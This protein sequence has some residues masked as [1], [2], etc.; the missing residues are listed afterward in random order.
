METKYTSINIKKRLFAFILAIT[1]FVFL[2]ICRL[3][4]LQV[5]NGSG[6]NSRALTQWLRDIKVNSIRGSFI[7]RNG[8]V[9]ASSKTVYDVYVRPREV[10]NSEALAAT[11]CNI[12]NDDFNKV[13]EK[14]NKK[15][16]SEVKLA[17][18]VE[19]SDAQK[20]I[21][22]KFS[23]VY[24]SE[25]SVRNYNYDSLLCQLLGFVNSDGD[26]QAG[27]EM[28]YNK[29]LKGVSGASLVES[30]NAGR[31]LSTSEQYYLEPINGLNLTLTIDIL[32]QQE[33]EKIMQRAM[34]ET[35]SARATAIVMD[36][37]NSEVLSI[38]T[39]PSYNLNDI[40]RD[41]VASLMQLSKQAAITD[42]YEPGSTFKILTTA[43]ALE[44]KL[45]SEN[46]Y[47]YCSGF[48]IVN[49]VK[50][51]CHRKTGH[52]SQSL[53]KGLSNSCNCVF[54]ELISRIGLEKFY[55]YLKKFGLIDGYGMDFPGEGKAIT[56]PKNLVID[57]DLY[58]MGFGQSVAITPMQLA[59]S[60]CAIINGGTLFRPHFVTNYSN[61]NGTVFSET[62]HEIR[63]VV[64]QNTSEAINRM[65]EKVVDGGGGKRAY[66]DG[67]RIAG[68][69][70]TAQK[71][72][73]NAIAKGKY[74]ASFIGYMPADNP[75]YL[76]LVVLDEP[77]GSFYGGVVAAPV[78]REIFE[79]IIRLRE[80]E[81]YSNISNSNVQDI[82]V[83]NLIGKTMTEAVYILSNLGLD[84]LVDDRGSETVTSQYLS[85]GS[86]C[87]KGDTILLV[88]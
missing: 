62:N 12:T 46:D 5:I 59:N 52:G 67:Y 4:Y 74:I 3:F 48:R 85:P 55:S 80:L 60:V 82:V 77:K 75:E 73:N 84:Y 71:Y 14:V 68:K 39:L 32:L 87:A 7:D 18:N 45:T 51:N 61:N 30:D 78:A 69:T 81:K 37:K 47:F 86:A 2:I 76:T 56:M 54:M 15:G 50:I 72:E 10:K 40:P 36:P 17:S 28:F 11:I 35:G 25:N 33:V 57:A 24:L 27:L 6:L 44:E 66:I 58:R 70:G 63:K 29:F 41:D 65:L 8:V 23:G 20:I 83:P 42:A 64:S 13:L 43:I 49:G 19:P 9:I 53:G 1:F 16:I 38:T 31:T 22:S 34:A 88:F 79:A 26:G 21:N